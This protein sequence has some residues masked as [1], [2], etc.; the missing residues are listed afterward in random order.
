VSALGEDDSA[1]MRSAG[2]L[3]HYEGEVLGF[4]SGACV[5]YTEALERREE[6]EPLRTRWLKRFVFAMGLYAIEVARG[7][8]PAPYDDARAQ[9]F[10][11]AFLIDDDAFARVR[12][13]A[14][15]EL[16]DLFGVPTAQIA[17]KRRDTDREQARPARDVVLE[18]AAAARARSSFP[19]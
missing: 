12:D 16:A 7:R 6:L 3:L 10:A 1:E 13:C 14:D 11:R 18:A 2:T 15:V 4:V 9:Y 5:R 8:L 17:L 19:R